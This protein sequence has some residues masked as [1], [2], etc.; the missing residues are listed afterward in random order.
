MKY[1][2]F[3]ILLFL[4]SRSFQLSAQVYDTGDKVGIGNPSPDMKLGVYTSEGGVSRFHSTSSDLMSG[5]RI[6]RS[7]A[8]KSYADLVNTSTGFGIGVGNAGPTLPLSTQDKS[9]I[10]I[11]ADFNTG[12][13]GIGTTTPTAELEVK[14]KANQNAEI[15]INSS[16]TNRPS[17]IRFQDAGNNSWGF[18]SQYPSQ[19]SFTLYNYQNNTRSLIV[20]SNNQVGIGTATMGSHRLAVGGTIGAREVKVESGTW[21][22]FV[23]KEDYPLKDLKEVEAFIHQN[24]HLPDIPSEAEV[25]ENGI[26]LGKMDAKL[27]QKIEELTLYTIQQQKEIE[28]I[29]TEN[30]KLKQ[31]LEKQRSQN[32]QMTSILQRLNKLESKLK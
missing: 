26:E 16:T 25:M 32:E 12:N 30:Q 9:F 11:F 1:Y 28:T 5:I 21:S 4:I 24:Q 18:L 3:I 6:G 8:I 19:G 14:A 2:H 27:L 31:Q 17:I 29:K 7:G 13:V 15:H 10:A 20:N 22:D 23:F